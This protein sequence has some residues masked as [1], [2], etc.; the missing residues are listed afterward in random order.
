MR[1]RLQKISDL[2]RNLM[3]VLCADLDF[4]DGNTL[5]RRAVELQLD[6]GRIQLGFAVFD[7]ERQQRHRVGALAPGGRTGLDHLR[8]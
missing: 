7:D 8:H 2:V 1:K 5:D 3:A 6:R 4:G